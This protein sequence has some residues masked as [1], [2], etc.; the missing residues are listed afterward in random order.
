MAVIEE[1][2]R[3]W[4]NYL[5][6]QGGWQDLIV[7]I[8]P[9]PTGCGPVYELANPIDR[10]DE[11]FAIVDMRELVITEPHYHAHG[12][13]EIYF[14]LQGVGSV[15]VGR[16]RQAIAPGSVIVT[17]PNTVHYTLPRRE[18][19]LAAVNTPPFKLENYIVVVG[20]NSEVGFDAEQYEQFKHEIVEKP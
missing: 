14:G 12:E 9:K 7:G 13:T 5:T 4:Q 8:E 6:N 16:E 18:V 2:V 15:V 11:S 19:V 3:V 1:V 10:P 17:P 20:T